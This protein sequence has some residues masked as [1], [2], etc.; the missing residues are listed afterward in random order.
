NISTMR[1]AGDYVI[2]P[3]TGGFGGRG[4]GAAPAGPAAAANIDEWDRYYSIN[5]AVT[6]SAPVLLTT[7]DGLIEDATYTAISPDGTTFYYCTNAKDIE[8]RHIWAVPAGGGTPR[9]V[10]TGDGIETGPAP[11]AS[12]KTLATLS[13]TWK[14][15][16]SLGI[17]P[18]SGGPQRIVFPTSRPGFPTDAHV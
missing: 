5:T 17:W 2:F 4:R 12:G 7:T 13:A 10:T 16:Q 1:A 9:Q 8:R 6:N 14:M 3:Y 15:P 18:A 11:L